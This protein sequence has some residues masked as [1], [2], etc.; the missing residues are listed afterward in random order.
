MPEYNV[1]CD[2]NQWR[3]VGTG[4]CVTEQAKKVF[5]PYA[6]ISHLDFRTIDHIVVSSF[7]YDPPY[8]RVV[9]TD[10]SDS[11]ISDCEEDEYT[12][13]MHLPYSEYDGSVDVD[14][15][16][17]FV[18]TANQFQELLRTC[19]TIDDAHLTWCLSGEDNES[20]RNEADEAEHL[21]WRD[22]LE[23]QTDELLT[24]VMLVHP[25]SLVVAER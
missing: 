5:V 12:W 17:L 7:L 24:A 11:D 22:V 21:L 16:Q 20:E 25:N 2:L 18:A 14:A 13:C 10:I 9:Y 23:P 4:L 6:E 8:V 19:G 15:C 1:Y 3:E